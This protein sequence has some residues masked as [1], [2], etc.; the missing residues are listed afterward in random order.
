MN[1]EAVNGAT[2][3]DYGRRLLP[4]VIDQLAETN[5]TR[6]FVSIPL[7]SNIEDGFQD[8]TFKTL[9]LAINRCAWWMEHTLGRSETFETLNYVGPQDLRYVLLLFAAI[10]NGYMVRCFTPGSL[11]LNIAYFIAFFELALKQ[12]GWAHFFT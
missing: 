1:L 4:T 2:S 9:A 11:S 3:P 5:P 10:K 6:V 12:P 8:I 7:T